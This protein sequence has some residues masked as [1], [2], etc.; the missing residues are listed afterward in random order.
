MFS[1]ASRITT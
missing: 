1:T